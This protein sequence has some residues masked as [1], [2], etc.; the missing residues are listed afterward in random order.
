MRFALFKGEKTLSELVGRLFHFESDRYADAKRAEEALL[1]ANPHLA[2][3]SKVAPGSVILIPPDAPDVREE[4]V[5]ANLLVISN[6]VRVAL[7]RIETARSSLAT[8]SSRISKHAQAV[9]DFSGSEEFNLLAAR[10]PVLRE[11]LPQIVAEAYKTLQQPDADRIARE[12][13]FDGFKAV[14]QRYL[15]GQY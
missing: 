10:N 1:R 5:P 15:T 7:D 3:L 4:T 8:E 9:V 14:L 12:H 13:A 11:R 2:D 6:L